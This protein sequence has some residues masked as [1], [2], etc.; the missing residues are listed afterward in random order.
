MLNLEDRRI[1]SKAARVST[2][3]CCW[4]GS[5]SERQMSEAGCR[6]R[7]VPFL[8]QSLTV[9]PPNINWQHGTR[10]KRSPL[11]A[12]YIRKKHNMLVFQHSEC[13]CRSGAQ[14]CICVFKKNLSSVAG[15]VNGVRPHVPRVWRLGPPFPFHYDD[16]CRD[17]VAVCPQSFICRSLLWPSENGLRG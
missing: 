9:V 13:L 14:L 1:E 8:P 10:S 11:L 17:A 6:R 2:C 5:V 16:R 12:P 15:D 4:Q 7:G 3:I